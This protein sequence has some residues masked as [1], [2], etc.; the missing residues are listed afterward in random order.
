MSQRRKLAIEKLGGLNE[1]PAG[2][3][4][5]NVDNVPGSEDSNSMATS[6]VDPDDTPSIRPKPIVYKT[7]QNQLSTLCSNILNC[8]S[9]EFT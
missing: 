8:H 9:V 6:D 3:R 2:H 7:S 5:N 4:N 1:H